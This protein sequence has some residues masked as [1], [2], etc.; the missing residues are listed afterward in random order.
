MA[1]HRQADATEALDAV[2]RNLLT[3]LQTH[4]PLVPRPF[5]AIG[6]ELGLSEDDV[7]A[8]TQ[9]MV[10]GRLIRQVG[11]IFDGRALGYDSCL[12]AAK[13]A[14]ERLDAAARLVSAH[15]GV[16]HNYQRE[17]DF[18]LWYTLAVPP[19]RPLADEVALLHRLTGADSTRPL[20]ALRMF[21]LGV[22]LDMD[23]TPAD[24][25]S[26]QP[27][28]GARAAGPQAPSQ[29]EIAAVRAFQ[30]PFA[31]SARP[32]DA[33]AALHGFAS[34]EALLAAG[35][36]LLR[37]GALRRFSAVL[38]HREAGFGANGMAVWKASP[39]ECAVAGPIMASFAKVSHC[40][41]RPVYE[42][43]PYSLFT[44]IHGRT[45][46]E[47][48]N[49]IAALQRETGL[50]EFRVL[51]SSVEYKKARVRY[52]TDDWAAWSRQA[53]TALRAEPVLARE[54]L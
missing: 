37:R 26:E 30:E 15:P 24:T 50:P 34:A 52:F 53:D 43:W 38:R 25:R 54:D 2:S 6:E 13:Y 33:A 29:H 16:S 8:R 14:P 41:Q 18:N 36:A 9:S 1:A 39:E 49:C 22:K 40:Y 21:K 27:V 19:G 17:H 7:V 3:R 51:Y 46:D 23:E 48:G 5:A 35:E 44:M 11:A 20:P 32:F 28:S 31:I 42:D 47:V 12:V 4:I 10:D 45:S